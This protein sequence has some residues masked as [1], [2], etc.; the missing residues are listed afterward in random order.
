[1]PE[2]EKRVQDAVER[3]RFE[4]QVLST[5]SSIQ[6]TL[7]EMKS[8][9]GIQDSKI[10]EKAERS[11]VEDLKKKVYALSGASAILGAL[12]SKLLA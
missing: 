1:M 6:M 9:H 2:E 7:E 11:D 4:G 8:K 5:L 3:G 12:L 10:D